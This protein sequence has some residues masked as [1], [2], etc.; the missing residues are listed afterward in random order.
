MP[1][2]IH[3][4]GDVPWFR[5]VP[6]RS[7][8][9]RYQ[10]PPIRARFDT[11]EGSNHVSWAVGCVDPLLRVV[12]SRVGYVSVGVVHLVQVF[13]LTFGHWLVGLRRV[14][15]GVPKSAPVF[16]RGL[17]YTPSH[18]N[19]NVLLDAIV[20]QTTVLLAQLATSS[21]NRTR[22]AN[23]ANQVFLN[24]VTELK[25]QGLG[26]KVI[27]DMFGLALR[28]YH[29][30][31]QRLAESNTSRGHSLSTAI[32]EYI[33]DKHAVTRHEVFRRFARDDE[34]VVRSVL[35]DL[36]ETGLL[37]RAG[38]GAQITYKAATAADAAQVMGNSAERTANLLWVTVHQFGPLSLADLSAQ[39]QVT[40][41]ELESPL[42]ELMASGRVV[43]E[44]T[45]RIVRYRADDC[46]I[47]RSNEHGWEAAVFDH[48]QAV[49]SAL[50]ARLR[51]NYATFPDTWQGGT[52]YTYDVWEGHE[53]LDEVAGFL[54]EMRKR[55]TELRLKVEAYNREHRSGGLR[56]MTFLSYV[57]QSIKDDLLGDDDDE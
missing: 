41:A 55:G 44:A 3:G 31:V 29:D 45:G 17:S 6:A 19:V 8:A 22:L 57:G 28:T 48:Y 37:F 18:M 4:Q 47:E 32:V 51:D 39:L 34:R 36:V 42:R 43:E 46:V 20:A 11:G 26:N 12:S 23:T 9:R 13:L 10:G 35:R 38:K 15:F 52:T 24:L 14:R 25:R 7:W 54:G 1:V 27:A 53:Y 56:E 2:K 30:K 21:G 49:V 5:P 16:E 40:T 33:Q 50:T